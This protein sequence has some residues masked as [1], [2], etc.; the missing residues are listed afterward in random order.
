VLAYSESTGSPRREAGASPLS[1][2]GKLELDLGCLVDID[3]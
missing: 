2:G 3:V 1:D